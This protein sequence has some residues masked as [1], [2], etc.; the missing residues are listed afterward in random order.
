[1]IKAYV[2]DDEL[3]AL[4]ELEYLLERY[5]DIEVAGVFEDPL[6]A[7]KNVL[8]DKPD[9]VFLDIDMPYINGIELALKIQTLRAG[10]IIIFVSAYTEYSLQAFKAYP[11]D[12]ILKPIDEDRFRETMEHV[13]EQYRLRQ[14]DARNQSKAS[15]RCFGSLEVTKSGTHIENLKLSNRKIKELFA[16]L[17]YRYG[18]SVPR[19]ELMKLLFDGV[20]DKKT[21]NHLH[22]TVYNLRNMLESFGIDRSLVEI[23]ENYTLEMANGVC[24]YIDFVNFINNNPLL[25][26]ANVGEAKRIIELY[27]G[28]YLEEEDYI[29]AIDIREWLE[30]R[31]ESLL[32][33]LANYYITLG[34]LQKAEQFLLRL[35][36]KNPLAEDGNKALL[37][38][39]MSER[40]GDKYIKFYKKYVEVLNEELGAKPD[41][42]YTRYYLSLKLEV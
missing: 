3:P 22:V 8:R 24:D 34:K 4:Q 1:M 26:V 16:Y 37:Q 40:D 41:A 35:V 28:S 9:V 42:K 38:L 11:L 21:I 17:I 32:L 20:E 14:T 12:Y 29:G 25:N 33:K 10:I 13:V 6:E 23:K 30:E 31:F 5:E 19:R 2:V 7:V 15:I 18:K 27:K 36:D 39:Y